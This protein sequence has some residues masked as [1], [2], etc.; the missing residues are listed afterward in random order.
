MIEWEGRV[1]LVGDER[2]GVPVEQSRVCL[3]RELG[4]ELFATRACLCRDRP[5]GHRGIAPFR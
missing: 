4:G 2:E 3:S 5:D 1:E